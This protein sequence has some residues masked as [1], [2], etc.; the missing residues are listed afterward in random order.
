VMII[1]D[2]G[3]CAQCTDNDS[4]VGGCPND[5]NRVMVLM[6]EIVHNL[7]DEPA[8]TGQRTTAVQTSEML[9]YRFKARSTTPSEDEWTYLKNRRAAKPPP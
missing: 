1:P 4:D 8:S 2:P 6:P 3:K 9:Q 7:E 5:E